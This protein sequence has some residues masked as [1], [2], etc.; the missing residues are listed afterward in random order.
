VEV[1]QGNGRMCGGFGSVARV[2][3]LLRTLI[4]MLVSR[5]KSSLGLHDV[6]RLTMRV[7][8]NDL[9]LL[10]HVNNGVY[11]S[12]MD[13][14]RMDGGIRTG[15]WQ[16]AGKLGWYHVAANETLTFRRSLRLWQRYTLET[17]VIGYDERAMYVEQRF[18][19]RGEVCVQG[20]VRGRLVKRSGGTVTMAE[21]GEAFGIDTAAMP[22][23]EWMSRWS[24][25][26][27]MPP[28]K[29]SYVSDW[30]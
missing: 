6:G 28:A 1:E 9:D 7:L 4:L 5:R 8:P 30:Q 20:I 15:A 12:L 16:K 26:V 2:N 3:M 14:G 29:A 10:G 25:D 21:Y 18:V 11:F 24:A 22:V 27:A 17:R 19:F 23:P 13:L